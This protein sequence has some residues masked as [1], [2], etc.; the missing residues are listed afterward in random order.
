MQLLMDGKTSE[1]KTHGDASENRCDHGPSRPEIAS[2]DAQSTP[3]MVSRYS[4]R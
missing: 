3:S 4:S 1:R 2:P